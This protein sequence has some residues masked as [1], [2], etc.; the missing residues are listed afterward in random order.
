MGA[1]ENH[2][3]GKLADKRITLAANHEVRLPYKFVI[4][5]KA[6]NSL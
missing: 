5:K 2:G 6:P 4:V 3:G 1:Y